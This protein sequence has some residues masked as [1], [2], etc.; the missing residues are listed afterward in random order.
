MTPNETAFQ[1]GEVARMDVY[2]ETADVRK[3]AFVREEVHVQKVVDQE[4]V[5][6][7]E[8]IRREELNVDTEGNPQVGQANQRAAKRI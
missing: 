4:T 6:L 1:E 5:T 7:E 2:E 8:K 3:E